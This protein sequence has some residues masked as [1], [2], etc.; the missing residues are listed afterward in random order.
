MNVRPRG[1]GPEDTGSTLGGGEQ[2]SPGSSVRADETPATTQISVEL[3]NSAKSVPLARSVVIDF[4]RRNG[5]DSAIDVASLL[6]SEIVTNAV[7][8]GATTVGLLATLS[9]HLLRVE[10]S[11][12]SGNVP[13]LRRARSGDTDGRGLMVV[14]SL[15]TDWGYELRPSGK[16][17]W[18]ELAI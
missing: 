3:A 10:A 18:F 14:A 5:N 13:T 17:V 1:G 8:H 7:V 16:S 9:N 6:T 12:R 11:D 2:P 15:A 4:L